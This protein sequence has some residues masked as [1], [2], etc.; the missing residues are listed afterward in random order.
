MLSNQAT[1]DATARAV[2]AAAKLLL[3]AQEAARSGAVIVG[4]AALCRLTQHRVT[5]DL[6]IWL[7]GQMTPVKIE[8]AIGK[9]NPAFRRNLDSLLPTLDTHQPLHLAVKYLT[10][11][12][13][14]ILNSP[15]PYQ[16]LDISLTA[17][18]IS[19]LAGY[20]FEEHLV[21]MFQTST[22][23]DKDKALSHRINTLSSVAFMLLILADRRNY[24]EKI[25]V[26]VG[27]VGVYAISQ[28]IEDANDN[29]CHWTKAN[30]LMRQSR[31]A[32][33]DHQRSS[34]TG[35][36]EWAL[37][38]QPLLHRSFVLISTNPRLLYFPAITNRILLQGFKQLLV[39]FLDT[40]TFEILPQLTLYALRLPMTGES[41]SMGEPIDCLWQ[42]CDMG[43]PNLR[44]LTTFDPS[45]RS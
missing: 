44:G 23:P 37:Y 33:K 9:I 18:Y 2:F 15:G 36:M 19:I 20:K 1:L 43:G 30:Q 28:K 41:P 24:N 31:I 8:R 16:V 6:D 21:P 4:G 13:D 25:L 39:Q 12:H 32:W 10:R 38:K 22:K 35:S 17:K 5:E 34:F 45:L 11:L 3:S 29:I 42:A 40:L 26:F 27:I 7:T 14:T